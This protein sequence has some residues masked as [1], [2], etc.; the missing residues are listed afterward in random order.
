M[1]SRQNLHAFVQL[2]IFESKNAYF[3][4]AIDAK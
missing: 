1:T 4:A 2:S 3:A